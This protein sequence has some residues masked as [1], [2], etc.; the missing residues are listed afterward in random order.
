MTV[1]FEVNDM[2]SGNFQVKIFR[3]GL[4]LLSW[5]NKKNAKFRISKTFSPVFGLDVAKCKMNWNTFSSV[6]FICLLSGS[7]LTSTLGWQVLY[8]LLRKQWRRGNA[9][10]MWQHSA[11]C[12]LFTRNRQMTTTLH[13]YSIQLPTDIHTYIWRFFLDG[14]SRG[15]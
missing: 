6:F 3:G 11:K 8:N 2:I 14:S 4:A 1:N 15:T 10:K 9:S 5:Q 7:C 13:F 12:F